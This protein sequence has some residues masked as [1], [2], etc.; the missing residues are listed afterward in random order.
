MVFFSGYI[1]ETN[2]L[3]F[4]TYNNTNHRINNHLMILIINYLYSINEMSLNEYK[5][6]RFLKKTSHQIGETAC[7]NSLSN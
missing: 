2:I 1:N 5:L 4:L 7:E 6:K 3:F